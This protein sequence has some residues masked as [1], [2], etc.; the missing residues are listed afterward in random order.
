M[1]KLSHISDIPIY[2]IGCGV[3]SDGQ[4][5]I[6]HDVVGYYPKF[7]PKFAKNFAAEVLRSYSSN[8]PKT[9]LSGINFLQD[10]I[11]EISVRSII[12]YVRQV[13]SFEFP[14]MEYCYADLDQELVNNQFK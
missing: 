10:G 3:K 7:R 1:E 6:Y 12:E 9:E 5:L 2:G 8:N 4:L 14:T 11:G 13:K